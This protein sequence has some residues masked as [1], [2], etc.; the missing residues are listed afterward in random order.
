LS[1]KNR[2]SH[3]DSISRSGDYCEIQTAKQ[4]ESLES[5][6]SSE[7]SESSS[8]ESEASLKGSEVSSESLE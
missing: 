2:S 1:D 5:E 6:S 3:A 8:E 4:N 7:V